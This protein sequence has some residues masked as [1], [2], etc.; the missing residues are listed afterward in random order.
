MRQKTGSITLLFLALFLTN[1]RNALA[2]NTWY[3][4]ATH[5]SDSNNGTTPASA[6]KTIARA[7]SYSTLGDSIAV[8]AGTYKE[9]LSIGFDLTIIGSNALTTSIDG[10]N[11]NTVVGINSS[12]A[13]VNISQL[14]I[15]N[16]TGLTHG[17]GGI[18]NAGTLTLNNVTVSGN[19]SN[20]SATAAAGLG[21][22]IYNAGTLTIFNSTLS[23]N[24]VTRYRPGATPMGGGIYNTGKLVIANSTI[25]ANQ[26]SD[27]YPAGPPYGGGVAS[28]SG[29]VM[30]SSTTLS[31][32]A[33][34]MR[35]PY[36]TYASYGGGVYNKA[37][38]G[39]TFQNSI[40]ALNTSGGNC[41]GTLGSSG[42]NL[43]SDT[44]CSFNGP[45]EQKNINP[46]LGAL[47]NNGGPT[48]TMA[49]PAGSPAISAGNPNGC[50]D[51]TGNRLTTDQRGVARPA[52][53]A[54]DIGAYN[55]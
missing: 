15:T 46:L 38:T 54:C 29:T 22:G 7:I 23:G 27:N 13:H 19:S 1:A 35:T 28:V 39:V 30:I 20:D 26:A 2:S 44:S 36:G 3:V 8:A 10:S 6:C 47:Q 14:T 17:G 34:I 37:T 49:L 42:Y 16:G 4:D 24:S 55:H 21:G 50:K 51:G 33:A 43:S 32:N 25:A 41:Y 53:G 18:Y 52:T 12:G 5:G 31:Q 48:Q 45:G 40:L 9:N 11:S